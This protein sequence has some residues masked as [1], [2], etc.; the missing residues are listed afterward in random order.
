MQNS[1]IEAVACRR[2]VTIQKCDQYASYLCQSC[3]CKKIESLSGVLLSLVPLVCLH[4]R[5]ILCI[6]SAMPE[7]CLATM[8][9]M[10]CWTLACC[11]RAFL[12]MWFLFNRKQ[13]AYD[14]AAHSS[15]ARTILTNCV[16]FVYRTAQRLNKQGATKTSRKDTLLPSLP[17]PLPLPSCEPQVSQPH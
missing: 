6:V 17:L 7:V 8:T 5:L 14:V 11:I 13:I 9:T 3:K 4:M 1:W 10:P 15:H 12:Y 2:L 16:H